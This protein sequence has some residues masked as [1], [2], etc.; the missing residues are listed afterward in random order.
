MPSP[1]VE[2]SQDN[3]RVSDDEA[4]KERVGSYLS[5]QTQPPLTAVRFAAR[6]TAPIESYARAH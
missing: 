1:T 4:R 2:R 3:V 5:A 6:A